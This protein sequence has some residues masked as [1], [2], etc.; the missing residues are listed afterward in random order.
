MASHEEK[1]IHWISVQ[2]H[3]H[4]GFSVSSP[5]SPCNGWTAYVSELKV[6]QSY[7]WNN[8]VRII[9]SEPVFFCICDVTMLLFMDNGQWTSFCFYDITMY[10]TSTPHR[11]SFYD[12][13]CVW[14]QDSNLHD[15]DWIDL[16]LRSTKAIKT[17]VW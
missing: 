9:Y 15:G 12:V 2:F 16:R 8:F 3:L 11:E 4:A 13:L 5:V 14:R 17:L 10:I 6:D 1:M 7:Q